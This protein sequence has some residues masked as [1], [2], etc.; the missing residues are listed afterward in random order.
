M[1]KTVNSSSTTG[2]GRPTALAPS[3]LLPDDKQEYYADLN[4]KHFDPTTA[5]G[6]VF[7]AVS[8]IEELLTVA[9]A[10]SGGLE[11]DDRELLVAAGVSAEALLP[12]CR[13]LQVDTPGE[14]GLVTISACSDDE[15][16]Q[17]IRTKE[18]APLSLVVKRPQLDPTDKATLII[19]PTED[20]QGELVWTAHPGLPIRPASEDI[21]P[22]GAD[23][24][25]AQVRQELGD[26]I[27]LQIDTSH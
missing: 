25:V 16:V 18:G 8:S 22:E 17:T 23:L 6:S 19:G 3:D 15:P 10:E 9:E 11:R 13:Y 7:A 20:G 21:W 1:G 14:V 12:Q 24:T 4:R 5:I 2:P 26:D 27:Y